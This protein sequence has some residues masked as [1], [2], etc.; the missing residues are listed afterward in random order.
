[1]T[2]CPTCERKDFK[3][4]QGMRWHHSHAHGEKLPS[5]VPCDYCGSTVSKPP[6][7]IKRS[8]N[9]FC[10]VECM[11]DW[12][13]GREAP[14]DHNFRKEGMKTYSCDNCDK[15]IERYPSTV[16]VNTTGTVFC[17]RKCADGYR[18]G[19]RVRGI[20]YGPNWKE[21]RKA[22]L[23]KDGYEC[24]VCKKS[25]EQER[26]DL[27]QSL[28]VHH[29]RK[30]RFFEIED[31]QIDYD[32]ANRLE[33]LLTLCCKCHHRWEGIPLRPMVQ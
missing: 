3:N 21:Q 4:E 2:E 24:V 5:T 14:P 15:E 1:M 13:R 31:G 18:T 19:N 23:E 7:L 12:K 6:S 25:N 10:D 27:G 26:M 33:N 11:N 20:H 30:A 28:Q 8:E 9:H 32:K 17:S 16:D 29:I 22:R